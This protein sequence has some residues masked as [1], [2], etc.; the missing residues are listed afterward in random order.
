ME[1]VELQRCAEEDAVPFGHT[2]RNDP[3][4]M[5]QQMPMMES[6][7]CSS[8]QN[9]REQEASSIQKDFGNEH[10]DGNRVVEKVPSQLSCLSEVYNIVS[11]V[12]AIV[13]HTG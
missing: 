10:N 6:D 8:G 5:D 9:I 7:Q 13:V 12:K 11:V 3:Y 2:D 4:Y 1:N